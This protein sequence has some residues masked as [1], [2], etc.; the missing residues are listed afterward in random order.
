MY[1]SRA[2]PASQI[3]ITSSNAIRLSF[4]SAFS[5]CF[6]LALFWAISESIAT[7][8]SVQRLEI[9]LNPSVLLLPFSLKEDPARIFFWAARSK[10]AVSESFPSL[11]YFQSSASRS[12]VLSAIDQARK[13][14]QTTL[15]CRS[16]MQA[17]YLIF[18]VTTIL[19]IKAEYY[20]ISTPYKYHKPI[21]LK[22][23]QLRPR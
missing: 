20:C 17:A 23:L 4:L 10:T 22:N 2:S 14:L 18:L 8:F 16:F 3:T 11:M 19:Q 13:F 6:F 9:I 21:P 7:T 15:D 5:C 12:S 1:A